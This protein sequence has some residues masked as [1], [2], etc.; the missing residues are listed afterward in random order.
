MSAAELAECFGW[1]RERCLQLH[2]ICDEVR[3]AIAG[4]LPRTAAY[5]RVAHAHSADT[6]YDQ[7]TGT[8][9]PLKA[10][11]GTL[12]RYFPHWEK[13]PTPAIFRRNYTGGR[14]KLPPE[15]VQEL[16]RIATLPGMTEFSV[17][18]AQLHKN[19]KRGESIPG[20]GTWREYWTTHPETRNLPLPRTV[21]DFPFSRSALYGYK[22][23]RGL[24]ALG[25][26]GEAEAR[27]FLAYIK[28]DYSKLKPAQLYTMDDVRLDL[29]CVD[30]KNGGRVTKMKVYLMME[31]SSRRIV[32]FVMRPKDAMLERDVSACLGRGLK[33]A[34]VGRDYTT[35]ILLEHGTVALSQARSEWLEQV[36]SGKIKIYRSRMNGGKEPYPGSG[37]ERRT[38]HWFSKGMIEAFMRKLHLRLKHLAGQIGNTYRNQ[39]ATTG[40]TGQYTA[41]SPGSVAEE[42]EKLARLNIEYRSR[43]TLKLPMLDTFEMRSVLSQTLKDYNADPDHNCQDFGTVQQIETAP[44]VWVDVTKN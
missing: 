9:R 35:F 36:T 37:N 22:P 10:S 44:G 31:V 13:N 25:N 8:S 14:Q 11:A 7:D 12:R 42:A 6:V 39:P 27:K 16:Q 5:Q 28:R 34:G 18:I 2:E 30:Y 15:T 40:F 38:G 26:H 29:V 43:V 32:S 24:K 3:L 33:A 4:G 17:A 19:W 1:E 23:K 21:P 41:P 20:L